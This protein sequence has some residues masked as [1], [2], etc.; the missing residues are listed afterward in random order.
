MTQITRQRR[1]RYE[2]VPPASPFQIT[3]RDLKIVR[4][5]YQYRFLTS[6]QIAA[7]DGGSK[8][9]VSRRL[10]LLF[11]SGW[12]DRPRSQLLM[13]DRLTARCNHAMIYAL[14][15]MGARYLAVEL[16][17]P[18]ATVN[19]T[20][21]NN[22]LKSGFFLEHTIMVAQFMIMVELACK[23]VEGV[24]F[25]SQEEIINGRVG[26][27]LAK[28]KELGFQ[29]DIFQRQ[30]QRKPYKL[31][32]VPDGAFGLRFA[33][34][35]KGQNEAFFFMEADRATMPIRRAQL[36]RSSFYK[37]M[38]GYYHG[39]QA[40]VFGKTFNFRNARVLTVTSSQE[41]IAN[42]IKA[43]QDIDIRKIGL[44]MFLFASQDILSL[45]R[46]EDVF[47]LIWLT[48][49]GEKVRIID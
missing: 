26:P 10:N 40:G 18:L 3:E 16:D 35:V 9:G 32:V 4:A 31:A 47:G 20:A 29:V 38:V 17:L 42:M 48:G 36:F 19:W 27:I 7:L 43:G 5:V 25:I 34:R 45:T 22:E 39:W 28:D 1:S 41:R 15:R 37:K 21:K 11:H 12:L 30:G 14:G 6:E 24:E 44:G 33:G 2:R 8:Q 23:K 49:K 46:P 13:P